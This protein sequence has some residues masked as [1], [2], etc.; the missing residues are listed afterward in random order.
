MNPLKFSEII[1]DLPDEMIESAAEPRRKSF[2]YHI[3]TAAAAGIIMVIAA[4][5]YPKLRM[6]IPPVT[7]PPAVTDSA[8]TASETQTAAAATSQTVST[9]TTATDDTASGSAST[10]S[11]QQTHTTVSRTESAGVRTETTAAIPPNTELPLETVPYTSTLQKASA[12]T[13]VFDGTTTMDMIPCVETEHD[14]TSSAEDKP[15][16]LTES[17]TVNA[18]PPDEEET[19][20]LKEEECI[21]YQTLTVPVWSKPNGKIP[22]TLPQR[23]DAECGY[24]MWSEEQLRAFFGA[25]APPEEYCETDYDFLAIHC[26]APT[27]DMLILYINLTQIPRCTVMYDLTAADYMNHETVFVIP[28]PKVLH[29]DP[30]AIATSF[31][32]V[33][34]DGLFDAYPTNRTDIYYTEQAQN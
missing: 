10:V 22:E 8:V 25:D 4:A 12:D 31:W 13:A 33:E 1:S 5:I 32:P 6:Q 28:V 23:N 20:A 26:C 7:A 16:S 34:A 14:T 3:L 27:P 30:S 21:S 24:E 18:Y 29:I 15:T 11:P 9:N 17:T 19:T 2:P